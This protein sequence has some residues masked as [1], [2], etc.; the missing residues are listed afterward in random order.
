MGIFIYWLLFGLLQLIPGNGFWSG[1]GYAVLGELHPATALSFFASMDGRLQHF[2]ST[3]AI[4]MTIV[5]VLIAWL[6]AAGWMTTRFAGIAGTV[7]IVYLLFIWL[8]FNEAGF[9]GAY[10]FALGS[11][12]VVILWMVYTQFYGRNQHLSYE[13]NSDVAK[14]S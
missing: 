9:G 8:G 4:I 7:G 5:L 2:G 14:R 10:L 1:R 13:Q 6:I 12:P 11:T 3:H